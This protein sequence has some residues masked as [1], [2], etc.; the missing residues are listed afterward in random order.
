ME[1]QNKKMNGIMIAGI[2]IIG[3]FMVIVVMGILVSIVLTPLSSAREKAIEHKVSATVPVAVY[4]MNNGQNINTPIAGKNICNG[5]DGVWPELK[6]Y[7]FWGEL[8]DGD[9]SDG[10]FKY[11]A[12]INRTKEAVCTEGGCIFLDIH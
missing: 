12:Y 9:V 11:T 8:V 3:S 2:I 4:C 5:F 1:D 7:N 10:N 6:G